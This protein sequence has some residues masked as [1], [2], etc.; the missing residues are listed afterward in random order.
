MGISSKRDIHMQQHRAIESYLLSAMLWTRKQY[1]NAVE[2]GAG[3]SDY[4]HAADNNANGNG[5]GKTAELEAAYKRALREF[6]DFVL[7]KTVPEDLSGIDSGTSPVLAELNKADSNGRQPGA[8]A[9]AGELAGF[10]MLASFPGSWQT[11]DR[12]L[13]RRDRRRDRRIDT[14]LSPALL[15]V[16]QRYR[17]PVLIRDV[18]RAGLGISTELELPVDTTVLIELNDDYKIFGKVVHCRAEESGARYSAGIRIFKIRAHP[19]G[20][21][22]EE[23]QD[24]TA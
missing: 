16:G 4:A 22:Q 1:Q 6:N 3:F 15:S 21:T 2:S 13:G 7:N 18:S 14:Q 8:E 17:V 12:R 24:S 9:T 19:H 23:A 20:E 11:L 10:D 5:A